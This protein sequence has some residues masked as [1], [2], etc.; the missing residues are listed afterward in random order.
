MIKECISIIVPIYNS[1]KTLKKCVDS[2]LNQSY[3]NLDIILVDDGSMDESKQICED[4][5]LKDER[6]RAF[7]V[8]NGGVSSARNFGIAHSKGEYLFLIDSDDYISND[9]L[10]KLI[11]VMK[12]SNTDIAMCNYY[13]VYNTFSKEIKL[14]DNE[15]MEIK[16]V[17]EDFF[18]QRTKTLFSCSKLYKKSI[19]C[20]EF[21]KFIYCEDVLFVYENIGKLEGGIACVSEPLYYYVRRDEST[22]RRNK[23]IDLMDML[24]VSKI[25]VED[26]LNNHNNYICSTYAAAVNWSFYAYLNVNNE[27]SDEGKE[28]KKQALYIIRDLRKAVLKDK[29]IVLKTRI[30][31]MLSYGFMP[32]VKMIYLILCKVAL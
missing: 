14:Y 2:L 6:V 26:A 21:K 9:C 1:E 5:V 27:N 24:N 8:E 22:T 13:E 12:I 3:R 18:Y 11:N 32:L 19:I 16:K 15:V 10:E 25:L 7:H 20:K 29:N 30:A 31:C 28:L 17:I 4:Y 23:A